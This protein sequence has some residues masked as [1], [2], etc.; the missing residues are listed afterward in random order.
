MHRHARRLLKRRERGLQY[1]DHRDEGEL[2]VD[3]VV[4]YKELKGA[5]ETQHRTL[6]YF[7][8]RIAG[9]DALA[10]RRVAGTFSQLRSENELVRRDLRLRRRLYARRFELAL[11]NPLPGL[12]SGLLSTSELA[13]LWQ[14][15]PATAK[16]IR[17]PRST[18]RRALAPVEITRDPQAELMQDEHGPVGIAAQDRKYGHALMGG[19]GGGKTSCL[20]RHLAVAAVDPGRAI[21]L[22]DGKGPLAEAA[23]GMLPQGRTVHYLDLAEPELG[24]NPLES[25]PAP[26]PPPPCSYRR[27]SRR[28]RPGRS[29][30]PRT[31]SCAR[32]SPPSAP[33][34]LNRRSGT[35][36]ACSTS[37]A[38]PTTA[39]TSFTSSTTS[40]A[41]TSRATTGAANSPP[42]SATAG[43]A[44]Q[45]LNPPRNKLER[46]I[47]TTR[48]RPA[49]TPPKPTRPHHVIDR[50]EVLI[51]N[52]AKAEI[53]EDNARLIMQL[54]LALL[55]RALQSRQQS[56]AEAG[57][58]RG[59]VS[60]LFDEAHNVLTP[61][62]RRCSPKAAQPASKPSSP[63]STPPRSKTTIVRSGVRSLLQSI[64]IFRMRELDDARSLAGLA[65]DVYTDRIS[66]Q[67][68]K[69]KPD[70]ASPPTTSPASKPTTPSTSGS[71]KAH[72]DQASSP[73]HSPGNHL[74]NPQ[75]AE[76]HRQAQHDRGGHHPGHLPD[77]THPPAS[78]ADRPSRTSTRTTPAR[79]RATQN[80][81]AA[82]AS[83]ASRPDRSAARL[84][85]P[86][87]TRL[88]ALPASYTA[89]HRYDG[90]ML[91]RDKRRPGDGVEE[92][93]VSGRDIAIVRDVWRYRFLDTDQL[94]ALHFPGRT[95]QAVRRRLAKLFHAGYLDR[96]RPYSRQGSYP[97]TYQLAAAGHKLLQ[98]TGHL[99]PAA[100]FQPRQLLDYSY[101]VHDL[102]LNAWIIAYRNLL[103]DQLIDWHGET[104][105]H[106][107]PKR[108][109]AT[110]ALAEDWTP[111]G[112]KDPEP[113]PVF[114]DAVLTIQRAGGP[115]PWTLLIEHDR[116]R[117]VDKNFDKFRRYDTYLTAWHHHATLAQPDDDPAAP[118]RDLH[119]PNP[120]TAPS[121]H[122]RRRPRTHRPPCRAQPG[123]RRTGLPRPPQHPVRQRDRHA[124]RHS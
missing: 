35:S 96:F 114:P 108:Q 15:P 68:K 63:G 85:R 42:S 83:A 118:L 77:P 4:E 49:A 53:G 1:A 40:R 44:T 66:N 110:L 36:T 46:L 21:V 75:L 82:A 109:Q 8:L 70:S 94:A 28:T 116:T 59:Q 60:L 17:I 18:M 11:P 95:G 106:P 112:L 54:L 25:A 51:V 50:G 3:S 30:P 23:L 103:G 121:L 97:W 74:H 33:S 86:R 56:A 102:Q 122:A 107:P 65:M 10:V 88:M 12:R 55:H 9:D 76:H 6:S 67:T 72:P 113:K 71:P 93:R 19:Q 16:H 73:R 58:A 101:V 120:T 34:N 87:G 5:L 41:R 81:H 29:K 117:R 13:A 61:S 47:S 38:K 89:V 99:D 91:Q 57:Q 123:R 27:S 80:A 45:A 26:A 62:S 32:R 104:P 124:P 7:D 64:S 43:F 48:D 78:S 90:A 31:A 111:E 69:T 24:F 22:I 20:A 84:G 100:R 2:G 39:T 92:C 98:L 119:L 105:I 14:L 115:A 37:A 79:R 52:A